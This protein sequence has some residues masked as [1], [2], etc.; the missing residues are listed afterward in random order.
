MRS[1]SVRQVQVQAVLCKSEFY[2]RRR[3][4]L[5]FLVIFA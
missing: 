4:A 2:F 1:G 5:V 3:H